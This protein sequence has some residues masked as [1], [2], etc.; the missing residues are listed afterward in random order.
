MTLFRKLMLTA[1][2]SAAIAG[3]SSVAEAA[4]LISNGGFVAAP[5]G[6]APNAG[7]FLTLGTGSMLIPGWTVTGG[8]IDWIRG[9]WESSD[10]DT[11]SVDMNGNQAG[12]IAQTISTIIGR[13]YRLRF[14][15]SGNPDNGSATR[16][17]L[18]G[19]NGPL[20]PPQS[21]TFVTGVTP[22]NN[23]QNMNWEERGVN[24]TA[25]STSTV[26]SFQ[27]QNAGFFGA[28]IDNVSVAVPEPSTW[29]M[30]IIGFGAAGAVLRRRRAPISA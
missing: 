27:S 21:Y 15:M 5:G 17:V 30:M 7:S 25:T 13:T 18:L 12:T 2:A 3:A 19:A 29:A 8:N 11:Y 9:Y 1:A 16:L 6:P 26:I 10:G 23:R 28:A 14:D 24:F 22:L 20:A 4:N